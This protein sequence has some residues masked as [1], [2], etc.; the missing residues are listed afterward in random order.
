MLLLIS[1]N[2]LACE[3]KLE[4][5]QFAGECCRLMARHTFIVDSSIEYCGTIVKGTIVHSRSRAVSGV[6]VTEEAFL[7]RE[8]A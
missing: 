3:L 1:N 8:A 2:W 7:P 6:V 4:T 5:M